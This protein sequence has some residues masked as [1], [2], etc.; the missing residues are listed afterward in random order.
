MKSE[1]TLIKDREWSVIDGEFC[2]VLDFN[3]LGSVKDGKISALSITTPYA[4]ITIECKKLPGE[5]TGFITNKVDFMHLWLAFKKR[6]IKQDEEVIISWSKKHYKI[7]FLKFFP[8][9]WPKLRGMICQKGAFELLTD[10]SCKP[11]LRGEARWE[12]T[13]PIV[14]WKPEVME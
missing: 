13:R 2:R 4:S 7:K 11:E 9:L 12:A 3:P 14:Q 8:G 1:I 10:P 6:T 5:I